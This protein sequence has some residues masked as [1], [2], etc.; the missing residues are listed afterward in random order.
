MSLSPRPSDLDLIGFVSAYGS[1]Y[2]HS[3]WVAERAFPLLKPEHDQPAALAALFADQVDQAEQAL[4][5][6]LLRA[7]PELVGKLQLSEL[8]D[9]SQSEQRGAGLTE[10]SPEEMTEFQRLNKRY[11]ER[12][13]FPFIFA[14]GGFHRAEILQ[15]FRER[16]NRDPEAE[17]ATA[18]DQVHRIG[19]LRLT[20]MDTN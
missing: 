19:L 20:A 7:H 11:N 16:V 1:I 9:A 13:G 15:A 14:V 3:P 5:L 18:I 8:T 4:K 12:F 17:F 2:E 10:C 6:A